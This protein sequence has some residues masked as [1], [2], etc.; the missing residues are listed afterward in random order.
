VPPQDIGGPGVDP[1][2]VQMQQN[3]MVWPG[4]FTGTI[5]DLD[6]LRQQHP[7]MFS[8][9]I[10]Y[11]RYQ[12]T[13]VNWSG[14]QQLPDAAHLFGGAA[15]G[16]PATGSVRYNQPNV[17]KL[18]ATPGRSPDMRNVNRAL[19]SIMSAAATHLPPGYKVTVNEGYNA[20]GHFAGSAHHIRGQGALDLQITDPRGHVISNQGEDATG[21][22]RTLA[23][24]AL[25]EQRARYPGRLAWGGAFETSPGSGRSDLMHFDLNGERGRF[26]Q[27]RLS[28]LGPLGWRRCVV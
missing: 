26:A 22:Y 23:R 2:R 27:N 3:H 14:L 17:A 6:R 25:G 5:A 1:V 19:V 16:Y 20:S 4:N 9:P 15:Q 7:D 24:A 8:G 12:A 28:V 13:R 21:M 10:D 11:G 18:Q